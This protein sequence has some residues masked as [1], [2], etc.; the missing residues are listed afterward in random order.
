MVGRR[1]PLQNQGVL[2]L[3]SGIVD[4]GEP[5]FL[6]LSRCSCQWGSFGPCMHNADAQGTVGESGGQRA[7]KLY[8]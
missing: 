5:C 4:V 1:D 8:V 7:E 2:T 6:W 3:R